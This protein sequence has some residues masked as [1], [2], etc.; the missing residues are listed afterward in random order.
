M[1]EVQGNQGYAGF[2]LY[3]ETSGKPVWHVASGPFDANG[4][5]SYGFSGALLHFQG[6]QPAS[7]TTRSTPTSS[8]IGNVR[9]TFS[10]PNQAH[11]QF[12]ART[13]DAVHLK[14]SD[15][16]AGSNQAETGWFWNPAEAGRSYA[17]EV[18]NNWVYMAMLHY[19]SDGSPTWNWVQGDISTG[20]RN[21]S[22]DRYTGGQSLS[23]S[24]RAPAAPVSQ[25]SFSIRFS[26]PCLG[27]M[28]YGDLP[29][30][31]VQRFAFGGLPS[32][33]ECR[34]RANPFWA[35]FPG[36]YVGS[37]NLS[38]WANQHTERRIFDITVDSLG[39][40]S[41]SSKPTSPYQLFDMVGQVS[42]NGRFNMTGKNRTS[43][44][45]LILSDVME[46][47][48]AFSGF[49]QYSTREFAGQFTGSKIEEG[50]R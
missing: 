38:I 24:K 48:C 7:S 4:D 31:Q 46:K 42:L 12:P 49:V 33:Q 2:L 45:E 28:Q 21:G 26:D 18:Q 44:G 27:Q 5:G 50:C 20:T 39:R 8:N 32:G 23:G 10:A 13:M 30:V 47:P 37:V 1:F 22:F 14:L 17:V 15:K 29:P 41:D 11:V 43:Q 3:D 9:I 25:G 19:D 36:R 34:A 6:G 16:P 35:M 40:I